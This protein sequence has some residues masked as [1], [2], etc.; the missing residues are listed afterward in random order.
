VVYYID[1]IRIPRRAGTERNSLDATFTFLCVR[2]ED[3]KCRRIDGDCK[4]CIHIYL[5]R[6]RKDLQ[7]ETAV[8][9]ENAFHTKSHLSKLVA[10]KMINVL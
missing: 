8:G 4:V 7:G 10:S 2:S 5:H 1:S 6:L 3:K 9:R